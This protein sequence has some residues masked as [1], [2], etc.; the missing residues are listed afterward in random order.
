MYP[1]SLVALSVHTRL[2]ELVDDDTA[3]RPVG[4]AGAGK[5]GVWVVALAWTHADSPSAL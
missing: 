5:G 2:I 4:A 3:D 1:A